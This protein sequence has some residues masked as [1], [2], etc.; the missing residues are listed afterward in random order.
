MKILVSCLFILFTGYACSAQSAADSADNNYSGPYAKQY[1]PVIAGAASYLFPGLGQVYC[2]ETHRGM[3]FMQAVA[4]GALVAVVGVVILVH[5]DAGRGNENYL[6]QGFI[7]AGLATTAVAYFW[8]IGDA[9]DLAIQ[10]NRAAKPKQKG[11]SFSYQPVQFNNTMLHGVSC[12]YR[13]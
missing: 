7:Y 12:R 2:G 3:L 4:G 8:G 1:S 10:K 13:F 9:V 11:A 5:T 6:G